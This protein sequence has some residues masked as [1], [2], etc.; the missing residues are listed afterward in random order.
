MSERNTTLLLQ[1]ILE[2][3][4]NIFG[5]TKGYTFDDYCGDIKTKYAVEHNFMIIGEAVARI[6][7]PYKLQHVAINWRLVKDFR[8]VIVHDNF[9][10]E[11]VLFGTLYRQAFLIYLE[12]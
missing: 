10:I 5:F 1:D 2:A 3:V 4:L 9:G 11:I 12:K 7:D 8:N 6:P